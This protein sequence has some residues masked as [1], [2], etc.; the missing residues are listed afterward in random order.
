MDKFK[1]EL[2]SRVSYKDSIAIV[3]G[4]AQY[5]IRPN[6]MYMLQLVEPEVEFDLNMMKSFWEDESKLKLIN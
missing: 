1:F 4:R 6:N 3:L 5:I 2:N